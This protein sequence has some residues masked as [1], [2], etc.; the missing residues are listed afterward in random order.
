[1]IWKLSLCTGRVLNES[2]LIN[3]ESKRE[4]E[5][6]RERTRGLHSIR[7]I[8]NVEHG[9]SD[10]ETCPKDDVSDCFVSLHEWDLMMEGRGDSQDELLSRAGK[11][12]YS[13]DPGQ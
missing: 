11:A 9:K 4:R 8:G 10:Q 1:M 13:P 6:E 5:R 3:A 12:C 2:R 7:D